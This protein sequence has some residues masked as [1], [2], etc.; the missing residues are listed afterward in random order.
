MSDRS[1]IQHDAVHYE[2][3]LDAAADLMSEHG[4]NVEYDRALVEMVR[5]LVPF[6]YLIGDTNNTKWIIAGFLR[7]RRRG[8]MA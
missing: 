3:V 1:I 5:D 7:D 6:G 4:E 8:R 2:K